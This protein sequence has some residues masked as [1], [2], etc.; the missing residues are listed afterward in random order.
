MVAD[1]IPPLSYTDV[2]LESYLPAGWT[3]GE[4]TPHWH[5]DKQRFHAVVLDGSELDWELEIPKAEADKH[6]RIEALRR[7]VDRLDRERFKSF[8]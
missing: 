4:P 8:L 6:G 7:A 1:L 2:E 5:D 3:L